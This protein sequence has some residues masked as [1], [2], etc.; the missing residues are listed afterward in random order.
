MFCYTYLDSKKLLSPQFGYMYNRYAQSGGKATKKK[1]KK[2][3]H[4]PCLRDKCSTTELW[5]LLHNKVSR[6]I[7]M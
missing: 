7:K 6:K 4:G 2:K 5:R 1:K 3:S